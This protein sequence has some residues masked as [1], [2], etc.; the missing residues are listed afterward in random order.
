M[1]AIEITETH[2]RKGCETIKGGSRE[3]GCLQY[4]PETFK[5]HSIQVLGYVADMT[6]VT[7]EYVATVTLQNKLNK[8]Y[9]EAQ[10]ALE[11]NAGGA[12]KCGKGVNKYGV[13]YN[14]CEYVQKVLANLNK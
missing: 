9:T 8:G 14:S 13:A 6:K 4:Q 2:G 7:V 3:I 5:M 12:K 11:W 10:L 1:K